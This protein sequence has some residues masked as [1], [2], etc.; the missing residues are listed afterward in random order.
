MWLGIIVTSTELPRSQVAD[1]G[2]IPIFQMRKLR[3]QAVS[4]LP[5]TVVALG[6]LAP[7]LALSLLAGLPLF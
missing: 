6:R 7:Q 1:G 4:D 2:I 5:C 3:H